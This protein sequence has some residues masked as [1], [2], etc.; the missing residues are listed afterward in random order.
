M[1]GDVTGRLGRVSL[2]RFVIGLSVVVLLM[3]ALPVQ[4]AVSVRAY[5]APD[6]TTVDPGDLVTFSI[7]MDNQGPDDVLWAWANLTFPGTLSYVDHTATSVPG[8]T[9][10]TSAG[11]RHQFDFTGLT[12]ANHTFTVR[13]RVLSGPADGDRLTTSLV[14]GHTDELGTPQTPASA[15]ASVTVS[16][17]VLEVT[18]T[19]SA[20]SVDPG[21]ALAFTIA[22]TNTGSATAGRLWL[23]DTLPAEVSYVRTVPA[24]GCTQANCSFTNLGAGKGKAYDIQV[25]V[26]PTVPR[27]TS[28]TNVVQIAFTDDDGT[29]LTP[30]S[31][32]ASVE[33]RFLSDL[34]VDKRAD[35]SVA[36]P[37]ALVTFTTWYNN[38]ATGDVTNVEIRDTIPAGM[39]YQGSSPTATVAGN[40]ATWQ[41][42]SVAPG[43]HYVVLQARVDSGLGDG[44]VLVNRVSVNY[45]D[46]SGGVAPTANATAVV[47]V[48]VTTPV[49]SSFAKVAAVSAVDPGGSVAYTIY[50]NNT[51][52]ET[53]REV[54]ILDVIPPGTVLT[55]PS[56]TPTSN[57]Q[58]HEW[59]FTNVTRGNHSLTYT[60]VL[61]GVAEGTNLVNFASLNFTDSNGRPLPPVPPR[62]AV[63]RVGGGTSFLPLVGL[64]AVVAVVGVAAYGVLRRGR[65]VIDEVFLLHK[66]G[67]LIKHYTRRVRP[68]VDSDVLSGMLIAVQNF[69]NESFMGSE[70]LEKEGQLDELRFGEFK[71]VIERGRSVSVAAVLSGD[72]TDRIKGEVKAAI[73][74]M[75]EA[76]GETLDEWS[77]DM[78]SVEGADAYMQDL[79]AGRYA[80]RL[81]GKG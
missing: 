59:R 16:I 66:D 34:V 3:A 77:G 32:Q 37:G 24:G 8:F 19:P 38:T 7:S 63:V 71:I 68:D 42:P 30:F 15:Q 52:A 81:W 78:R 11:N 73:A 64:L 31:V 35:A 36:P 10:N 61:Q 49:F 45:T 23:N 46:A 21:D 22:V 1:R 48:S 75:E 76:L 29:P 13:A 26:S 40:I 6:R 12:V 51:G 62:S 80:R 44:A 39:T 60:L 47:T 25:Q 41:Q 72:P 54:V 69:V 55:N 74:D 17:P 79:I 14:V 70:G 9:G 57:G 2:R 50:Y 18:K 27:G 56:D 28:F 33:V 4:G 43:P 53:A 20:I 65:T 5:L 67:L 58:T